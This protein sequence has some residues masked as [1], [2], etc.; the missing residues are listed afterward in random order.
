MLCILFFVIILV[1]SHINLLLFLHNPQTLTNIGWLVCNKG[2][3]VLLKQYYTYSA[4]VKERNQ[5]E[6]AK[7][8]GILI[9]KN[10]RMIFRVLSQQ[11]LQAR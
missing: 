8:S 5:E 10:A 9:I 3:H 7:E 6:W 11:S 1:H 4:E 2:M